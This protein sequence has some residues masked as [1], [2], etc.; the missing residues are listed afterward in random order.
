MTSQYNTAEGGT[1]GVTPTTSD[2]GS[3]DSLGVVTP[4]AVST[5]KYSSAHP[6]HG[7]LGYKLANNTATAEIAKIGQLDAAGGA[8]SVYG[9]FYYLCDVTPSA[10]LRICRARKN[11]GTIGGGVWQS[12]A[13]KLMIRD[14]SD[15]TI[16][17]FTN[18]MTP[19]TVYRIEW[20][21]VVNGTTAVTLQVRLYSG[22]G[23]TVIED[24]GAQSITAGATV[25]AIDLVEYGGGITSTATWPDASTGAQYFDDLKAFYT[26]WTGPV[27]TSRSHPYVDI[28]IGA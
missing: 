10:S 18:A 1:D 23:T 22:D 27:V 7:S 15:A 19:G 4:G 8:A 21:M 20:E 14:G 25:S 16:Y 26:T 24:S 2:T 28:A 5:V 13:N 11:G 17:T 12:T 6:A 9:S 3:G